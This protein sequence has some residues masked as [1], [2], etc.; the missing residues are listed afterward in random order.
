M[1][2]SRNPE[3]IFFLGPMFGGKSSRLLSAIERYR[4]QNQNVIA[5]KPRLDQRY[6]HD[7]ISTH[8]GGKIEAWVV[9]SGE[10]II[11]HVNTLMPD[12]IAVDEAFMIDGS[13]EAL[14]QIYRRGISVIV[15]SIELSAN[16]NTF[17]EIEK[18]LPWA[19]K[20]EK[21]MAVCVICKEDAPYT[22]K[23]INDIAE[24]TVGGAELYEP[25]CWQHHTNVQILDE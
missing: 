21:C 3:F 22:Q 9:N 23:K 7:H 14:I 4:Y 5:F 11:N 20:I 6:S 12:V 16:C 24:I 25:R 8:N 1:Q 13:A 2:R 10:E 19:T 18:M 17:I 15:S